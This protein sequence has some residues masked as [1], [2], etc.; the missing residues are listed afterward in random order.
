M[1]KDERVQALIK[2]TIFLALILGAFAWIWTHTDKPL[3]AKE[4]WDLEE[5]D[6]SNL[7]SNHP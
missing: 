4:L 1:I 5:K 3:S 7:L 6:K 2:L